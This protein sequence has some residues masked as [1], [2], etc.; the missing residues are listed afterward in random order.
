MRSSDIY[1]NRIVDTAVF[2]SFKLCKIQLEKKA[3]PARRRH[4]VYCHGDAGAADL[5]IVYTLRILD[6]GL[7]NDI[8]MYKVYM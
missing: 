5:R 2:A 7:Y 1:F 3:V 6:S 8:P 4:G